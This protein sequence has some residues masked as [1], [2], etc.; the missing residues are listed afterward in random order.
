MEKPRRYYIFGSFL[1]KNQYKDI[2]ILVVVPERENIQSA[3]QYIED[4]SKMNPG[5]IVHTQ[6]YTTAEYINNENKFSYENVN[7]EIAESEFLKLYRKRPTT[8]ST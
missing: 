2:D 6:I 3:L 8:A 5:N 7:T 4:V 1:N